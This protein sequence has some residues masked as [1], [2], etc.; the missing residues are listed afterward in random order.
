MSDLSHAVTSAPTA[1]AVS[2]EFDAQEVKFF[3]QE[4]DHATSAIARMLVI[5]F[6]YSL[7]IMGAV[8]YVVLVSN[9]MSKPPADGHDAQ[10]HSAPY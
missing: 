8:V 3:G 1:D 5:F 6:F 9:W 7:M 4:D 2:P 10:S